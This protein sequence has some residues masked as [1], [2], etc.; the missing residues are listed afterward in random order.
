M[1]SNYTIAYVDGTLTINPVVSEPPQGPS[2]QADTGIVED[3]ERKIPLFRGNGNA[4]Y[5]YKGN[6]NSGLRVILEMSSA[7]VEMK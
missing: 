6:W 2:P 4:R 7:D 3:D 1:A 5:F